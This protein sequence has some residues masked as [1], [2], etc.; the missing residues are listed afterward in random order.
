ML[1]NLKTYS[2]D[3]QAVFIKQM[4]AYILGLTRIEEIWISDYFFSL[5]FYYNNKNIELKTYIWRKQTINNRNIKTSDQKKRTW[6]IENRKLS[7][8]FYVIVTKKTIID[9]P[10]FSLSRTILSVS[11]NPISTFFNISYAHVFMDLILS[12]YIYNSAEYTK[13]IHKKKMTRNMC[14]ICKW[15]LL[16]KNSWKKHQIERFIDTFWTICIFFSFFLISSR[17]L[18]CIALIQNQKLIF[19]GPFGHYYL[20]KYQNLY[21]L[22]EECTIKNQIGI[23]NSHLKKK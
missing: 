21:V 16:P 23:Q 4:V 9:S 1:L 14:L 20:Q 18:E 3:L 17:A 5:S 11:F 22:S 12:L 7:T 2:N 13:R 10:F 6:N 8:D 15:Y 19:F